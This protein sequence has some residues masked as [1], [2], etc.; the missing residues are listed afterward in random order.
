MKVD[1]VIP[2]HNTAMA[3][4]SSDSSLLVRYEKSGGSRDSLIDTEL[5]YKYLSG[6]IDAME[7]ILGR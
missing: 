2:S 5:W 1:I 4:K 7:E 6:Q 3:S